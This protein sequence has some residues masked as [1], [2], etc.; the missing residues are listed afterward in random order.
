VQRVRWARIRVGDEI[1]GEMGFGLL[2]LVAAREGEGEGAA[3]E[4][5]EKLVHLRI[6]ADAAGRM[7]RSLLDVRGELGVVSQFTLYGD[8]RKGRRPSFQSA[9]RPEA[10]EPLLERVAHAARALGVSVVTGRFR[11]AMEVELSNDGPVTLL[12]DT[13]KIF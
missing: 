13:D 11:A 3:D 5:A 7:N 6:F 2:A 1:V 8:A 9:A 4:L 10:A 12:I